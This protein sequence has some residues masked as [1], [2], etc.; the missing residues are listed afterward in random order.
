MGN[1]DIINTLRSGNTPIQVV[2]NNQQTIAHLAGRIA[3]QL[4][5]D[6]LSLIEEIENPYFMESVNLNREELLSLFL[7]NSY[8]M[9]WNISTAEFCGACKWKIIFFG[10]RV[11]SQNGKDLK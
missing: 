6:S 11:G 10:M 2:F 1:H 8:E 7:P 5:L 9:Y 3:E 4:E